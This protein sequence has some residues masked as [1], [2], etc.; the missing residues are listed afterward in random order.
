[1]GRHDHYVFMDGCI[2][3]G[4]HPII[5][6]HHSFGEYA[7]LLTDLYQHGGWGY[8]GSRLLS[9][10]GQPEEFE[11]WAER[12]LHTAQSTQ[13]LRTGASRVAN[14]L[15]G[16]SGDGAIH[17]FGTS[18]AGAAMLEYFLLTDP[19]TLYDG[20]RDLHR[21]GPP[22]RKYRIDPRIASFTT[23]DAPSNWVPLRRDPHAHRHAF[24]PGT[25]GHYL[26]THT[27]IQASPGRPADRHTVRME[28]VP[29]TWVDSQ[30]VAGMDY[31]D[32]P[33]YDGLPRIGL[34]RHIYTGGHMSRETRAFL[35]RVWQ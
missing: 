6:I 1:M 18:A 26:V 16:I 10:R 30:P 5:E 8:R 33:H 14:I 12:H 23:I 15:H 21:V 27:R 31:D 24:G 19:A 32:R 4:C 3:K 7:A 29:H 28:D 35:T 20:E 22:A 13:N 34:E 2:V 25:L 11:D 17:L 9:W